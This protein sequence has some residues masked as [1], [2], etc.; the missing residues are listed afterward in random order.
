MTIETKYGEIKE[1]QRIVAGDFDFPED[2]SVSAS[3]K[4]GDSVWSW[5]DPSNQRLQCYTPVHLTIDWGEMMTRYNIPERI[6]IDLKRFAFVRYA[7]SRE[8]FGHQRANRNGH[9]ATIVNEIWAARRLLFKLCKSATVENYCVIRQLSDITVEDLESVLSGPSPQDI[10]LKKVLRFLA[11][12]GFA[13][14]LVYGPVGWNYSDVKTLPWKFKQRIP[15]ERLPDGLF[16]LLSAAATSDVRQFLDALNIETEDKTD[17]SPDNIFLSQF[18][19]F[20]ELFEEYVQV[21]K[22]YGIGKEKGD[23]TPT[24]LY[25]NFC[26]KHGYTI[27]EFSNLIE[28]ARQA[29]ELIITM[30]T[31]ARLSELNSF[32]RDSLMQDGSEW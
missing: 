19:S 18:P 9:P 8:I 25:T 11:L 1:L 32:T 22:A 26:R 29:A 20:C 28:R 5:F 15:Y 16:R 17:G 27:G 2:L 10:V 21:R 23:R 12:P 14:I 7:Y 4:F 31:G 24:R 6:I 30:Y 3:S 13:K